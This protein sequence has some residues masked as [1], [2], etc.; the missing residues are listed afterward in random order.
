MDIAEAILLLES[1]KE[2]L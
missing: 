1:D 2:K